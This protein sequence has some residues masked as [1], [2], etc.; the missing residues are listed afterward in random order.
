MMPIALVTGW[1][2]LVGGWL[3]VGPKKLFT[4]KK[5]CQKPLCLPP[6][7]KAN[8]SIYTK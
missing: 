7:F 5:S 2:C 8:T 3:T 6:D 4:G 1:V